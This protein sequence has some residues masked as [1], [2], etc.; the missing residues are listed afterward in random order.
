M[1][2]KIRQLVAR[3]AVFRT[4][5]FVRIADMPHRAKRG[6]RYWRD[7]RR[8]VETLHHLQHAKQRDLVEMPEQFSAPDEMADKILDR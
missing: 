4:P 8:R 2:R 7:L 6:R 5:V 3:H 1:R